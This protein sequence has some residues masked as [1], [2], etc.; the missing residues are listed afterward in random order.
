VEY[1][2]RPG[3][4]VTF[5]H[6][7][8]LTEVENIRKSAKAAT[9]QAPTYTAFIAKAVALA[10]R[11]FPYANRRLWG[12]KW[13]PFFG[14]RLQK[15]QAI[16]MAVACE[17]DVPGAEVATFVDILRDADKLSLSEIT[18]WL[19]E[20]NKSDVTNNEQWRT[21]SR[22]IRWCPS[23]LS[24]LLI[25]LPCFI[26]SL[27]VKYRGGA[28]LI[29]SPAKYGVDIVSATWSSPLGISFGLVR[30]RPVV[31]NGEIAEGR[32]FWFTLNFD[33]RVMAG[34]QAGKF[35]AHIINVLEHPQS[36]MAAFLPPPSPQAAP[37]SGAD[38]P[39]SSGATLSLS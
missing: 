4:T 9:G 27:W 39:T 12:P 25:R 14:T 8:D 11:K 17:R 24:T 7:V 10:L 29:S 15:F 5:L 1:E 19:Q 28:A 32:T 23:W 33:R 38:T 20:L 13:L 34:A 26:P 31:R 30:E 21:F 6:E 16:D 22:L 18:T 2:I 35:F 36:E 3:N 37:K